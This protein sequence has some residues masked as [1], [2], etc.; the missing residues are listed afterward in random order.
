MTLV[1]LGRSAS[2]LLS[3]ACFVFVLRVGRCG[4]AHCAAVLAAAVGAAAAGRAAAN[5]GWDSSGDGQR[6]LWY[7]GL[8]FLVAWLGIS[9]ACCFYVFALR[10]VVVLNCL[11][12]FLSAAQLPSMAICVFCCV[13]VYG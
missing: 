12:L 7:L 10:G 9:P 3:S 13:F 1:G 6:G 8:L 2:W 5:S 4:L 11:F